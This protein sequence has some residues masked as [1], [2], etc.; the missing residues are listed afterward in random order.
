MIFL[1][2][3]FDGWSREKNSHSL[4][5][6][7]HWA[8]ARWKFTGFRKQ[9][10]SY[11]HPS[12]WWWESAGFQKQRVRYTSSLFSTVTLRFLM[13]LL[14]FLFIYGGLILAIFLVVLIF[15]FLPSSFHFHFLLLKIEG[16]SNYMS[17][18]RERREEYIW[19]GV[20]M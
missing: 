1:Q 9:V 13:I 10:S 12:K 20:K 3:N 14:D 19:M 16:K 17:R 18:L 11:F 5:K 6:Y 2:S 7:L 15:S 8:V 4:Y